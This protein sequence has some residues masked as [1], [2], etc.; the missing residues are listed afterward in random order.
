MSEIYRLKK[1]RDEQRDASSS[2]SL[3]KTDQ[4][5]QDYKN[6]IIIN[7]KVTAREKAQPQ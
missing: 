1:Q 6:K 2:P 5:K 4:K 7:H 3:T